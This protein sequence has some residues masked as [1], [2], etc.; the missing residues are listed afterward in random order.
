MFRFLVIIMIVVPAIEIM[1][2]I[3]VGGIIGGLETFILIL[4][5][6][7]I[8]AF[9]AKSE[10]TKVM[11]QAR[12]EMSSGRVPTGSILDG[13]CIFSGGLLL[14]TPGF[15]TDTI[16]FMLVLPVTRGFFK[17]WIL[18]F[19]KKLMSKGTIIRF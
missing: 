6:G 10:G 7:F 11:N 1:G 14:L 19:I 4:L 5:T 3:A 17:G 15:L 18:Y 13:I 8:G 12:F 9:L 2:L 16:G